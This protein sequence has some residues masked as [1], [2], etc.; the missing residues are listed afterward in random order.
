MNEN[1]FVPAIDETSLVKSHGRRTATHRRNHNHCEDDSAVNAMKSRVSFLSTLQQGWDG[2]GASPISNK[3][4]ANMNALLAN[5]DEMDLAGWRALPEIN[6]TISLQNDEKRA[7]IQ[8]GDTAFS[9]F[10]ISGN[11]VSGNDN[12]MFTI[13]T[14]LDVL[15]KING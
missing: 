11:H 9:Y 13:P 8:V 1:H 5:I 10:V 12:V 2:Y 14:L 6:G 3:V 4:V 15:R 7:G